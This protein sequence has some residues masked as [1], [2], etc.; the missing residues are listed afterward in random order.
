MIEQKSLE[1]AMRYD[2]LLITDITDC[3]W[4]I[5]THSI[6]WAIHTK[7]IAKENRNDHCLIGNIIDKRLRGMSF[8]QTN[9]IPQWSTL[10]DFIAEIVLGYA[11]L[12]LSNR[13][14]ETKIKD[15]EIIRYRDD[16]RIFTNNPQDAEQIT[17]NITEIMIELWMRLNNHKTS[18]SNNIIKDSV[19]PDKLYWLN[20]T[21]LKKWLQSSLMTIHELSLKFPNSGSLTKA[22]TKFF[23]KVERQ[24]KT[25]ENIKVLISILTDIA[26]KNP[27]TYPIISAILSKLL[28]LISETQQKELL[29]MINNK[30]EK[31]PNTWHLKIWLQR[32]TLKI[33]RAILYDEPLCAKVNDQSITLWNSDWLDNPMKSIIDTESIINEEVID[34]IDKTIKKREI[35]LFSTNN[36]Y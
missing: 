14:K 1:L 35:E 25:N 8:G 30:F 3:Y 16:Y 9:G 12:E 22:L 4:S 32:I 33:N 27:R 26:Y 28:S 13:I 2:Y 36:D 23:E 17:K 31:I 20:S 24:K 21:W 18:V 29:S 34:K 6:P 7:Q 19:K 11:D 5:Y 15:Y 10:M